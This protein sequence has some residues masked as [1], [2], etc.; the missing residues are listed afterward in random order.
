MELGELTYGQALT[1]PAVIFKAESSQQIDK[2]RLCNWV[3]QSRATNL[4]YNSS[5]PGMVR[6][7]RSGGGGEGATS[8]THRK[9]T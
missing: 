3:F 5:P 7:P 1:W 4:V 8:F 2:S 9:V 6:S